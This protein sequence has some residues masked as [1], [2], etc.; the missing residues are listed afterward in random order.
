MVTTDFAGR[1]T[2]RMAPPE[3]VIE[4]MLNLSMGT[5]PAAVGTLATPSNDTST[6]AR[7]GAAIVDTNAEAISAGGGARRT[8]GRCPRREG[9]GL[10]LVLGLGVAVDVGV[11]VGVGVAVDV[12][13]AVGVGVAV[14]VGVAVGVGVGVV[15][16]VEVAANDGGEFDVDGALSDVNGLAVCLTARLPRGPGRHESL[17]AGP[18]HGS[19]TSMDSISGRAMRT[20]R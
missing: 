16:G 17:G 15:P 10:G 9:P 1:F 13:V 20:L 2:V 14:D 12:G 5:V 7:D 4:L 6:N 19:P 11:A 3:N 18:C 8:R